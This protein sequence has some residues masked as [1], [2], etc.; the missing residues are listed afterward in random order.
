[1]QVSVE[2]IGSLG[3][4]LTVSVPSARLEGVVGLRLQEMAR[5]AQMKGFRRGKVPVAVLQQRFGAQVRAEAYGDL[6][7]ETFGEALRAQGLQPAGNPQIQPEADADGDVRFSATFEVVPDFG[8]ID[9]S[10]LQV[11]R[12]VATVSDADVDTMID[13]LRQQRRTWVEVSRPAGVGDLVNVETSAVVGDERV[14]AEGTERGTTIIGAGMLFPA[15][16][17]A[18]E[19]MSSGEEKAVTVDFPADWRVASLA[20]KSALVTIKAV[21]VSESVLPDLDASFIK[22]FG[23][24]SGKIEQ[25]RTE[26]QSNLERELKGALA[27]RLRG[28]VA[29]KLVAAFAHVEL[30]PKLVEAEAQSM[31]RNAEEQARR[32]GNAEAKADPA[33][34]QT[35]ARNRVAAALLVGE[36]ARQNDLRLDPKRVNETMNLI[37][38]TYEDPSQVIEL[39]RNDPNLMSGLQSRVMEEQ[40]I[41]WIAERAQHTDQGMSFSEAIRPGN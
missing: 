8:R 6:V 22:A 34:F 41:D 25:F 7:R 32:Q 29:S 4:R 38:S 20:G 16:E 27:G 30:P 18:L 15:L 5:T 10:A 19:G 33:T 3:R 17:T 11:T 28:E 12:P 26:V 14:P 9:V 36:V 35:A 23:V 40:V 1:M 2:S 24:K 21:R 39:Y 13:T 31:A 37:A